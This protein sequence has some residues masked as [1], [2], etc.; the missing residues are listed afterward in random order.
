V[1]IGR[2]GRPQLC[3][4]LATLWAAVLVAPTALLLLAPPAARA[5]GAYWEQIAS[6]EPLLRLPEFLLGVTLGRLFVLTPAPL[7]RPLAAPLVGASTLALALAL[8]VAPHLPFALVHLGLLDPLFAALIYGLAW[9]RGWL[10]ALLSRPAVLLLGEA[11]YG[12]YILHAPIWTWLRHLTGGPP[13]ELALPYFLAYL[14]LLLALAVLSLR[15]VE[16]PAR[17]VIRRSLAA[18]A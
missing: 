9:Q 12:I 6:Y 14:V 7:R 15:L 17:R 2:L 3:A 16:T 4:L 1:P 13:A 5:P 8:A 11:S 10:S 18:G